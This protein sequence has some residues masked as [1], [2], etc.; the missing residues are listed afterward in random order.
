MSAQPAKKLTPQEYLAIERQNEMKSEY[1]NGEMF[2]MAGASEAHNLIAINV[3][4]ELRA[5]LKE[6]PC[7]V[8]PGD[9]R[10]RIPR[11]NRYLY[12]DVI[13]VCGKPEFEDEHHDTLLNPTV[14]IE[15]FS[16]STENYDRGAKFVQ[17]RKL[18]AL[19]EYLLVAQDTPFIEHY[20]RQEATRF[21]MLSEASG[22]EATVELSAIACRLE[23]A[24]VYAK[25]EFAERQE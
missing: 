10:V 18:D 13:V 21:W 8:Y 16:P 20:A 12:P 22:L 15:V 19:R 1:W 7:K 9:M 25:V 23:L 6:R 2:A 24:E 4:A 11:T 17:Y 5:Q 14:I 3:G